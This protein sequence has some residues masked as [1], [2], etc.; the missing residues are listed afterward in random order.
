MSTPVEK[1]YAVDIAQYYTELA[2]MLFLLPIE[3][4]YF[5]HQRAQAIYEKKRQLGSKLP[6]WWSLKDDR[7][8]D[9]YVEVAYFEDLNHYVHV[10]PDFIQ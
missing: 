8:R 5:L 7:I 9:M 4:Q 1:S 6:P 2:E 10:D 3:T